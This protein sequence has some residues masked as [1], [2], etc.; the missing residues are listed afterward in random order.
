V[1]AGLSIITLLAVDWTTFAV[2]QMASPLLPTDDYADFGSF[3]TVAEEGPGSPENTRRMIV[4]RFAGRG[5]WGAGGGRG[6]PKWSM[7]PETGF[8]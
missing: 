1:K 8:A 6:C 5:H 4:G 7:R 2:A 3:A